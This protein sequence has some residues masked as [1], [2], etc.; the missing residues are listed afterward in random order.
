MR[1]AEDYEEEDDVSVCA[2]Q[3]FITDCSIS[4]RSNVTYIESRVLPFWCGEGHQINNDFKQFMP[5]PTIVPSV[6]IHL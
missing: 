5:L 2:Y 1:E 6:L 4:K 3:H